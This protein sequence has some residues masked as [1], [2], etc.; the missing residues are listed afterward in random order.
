MSLI[1]PVKRLSFFNL[2]K[3]C[4]VEK[5][6]VLRNIPGKNA[7]QTPYHKLCALMVQ[8]DRLIK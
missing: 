3:G 7:T 1:I 5:F 2:F 6:L 8:I 4:P